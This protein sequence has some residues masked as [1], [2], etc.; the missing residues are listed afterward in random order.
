MLKCLVIS[1]TASFVYWFVY[2]LFGI[3]DTKKE[4]IEWILKNPIYISETY[5]EEENETLNFFVQYD[6]EKGFRKGNLYIPMS[7]K[8]YVS[9]FIKE[10]INTPM[11]IGGYRE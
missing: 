5:N 10:F 1:D 8:E 4:A 9:H 3:I 7:K 6:E 11:Y 2:H